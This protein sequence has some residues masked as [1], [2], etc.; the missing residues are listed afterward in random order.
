MVSPTGPWVVR[1]SSSK[2]PVQPE[3]G[4]KGP[5][6]SFVASKYYLGPNF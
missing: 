2:E 1:C 4:A 5:N 3:K 6:E